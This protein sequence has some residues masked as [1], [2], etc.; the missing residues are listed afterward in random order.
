MLTAFPVNSRG[1]NRICTESAFKINV[2]RHQLYFIETGIYGPA[3]YS[4]NF[5]IRLFDA[6]L[7]ILP[8][9][10]RASQTSL[11][12]M[13]QGASA[14]TVATTR[15]LHPK[16]RHPSRNTLEKEWNSSLKDRFRS[17]G[18]L[19][20][21]HFCHSPTSSPMTGCRQLGITRPQK[22]WIQ[23]WAEIMKDSTDLLP[24]LRVHSWSTD[25]R[26]SS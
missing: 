10:L 19:F 14:A 23:I 5:S 2:L 4:E 9:S 11:N 26:L 20:V 6:T 16:H 12:W 21:F 17:P 1:A 24:P 8:F 22:T 3:F 7:T 13:A 18:R 25:M 15:T